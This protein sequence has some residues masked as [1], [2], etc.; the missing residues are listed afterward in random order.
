MKE[1]IL[2]NLE[3]SFTFFTI[4]SLYQDFFASFN[5]Y[6]TNSYV[7]FHNR[8]INSLGHFPCQQGKQ[9]KVL[10]KNNYFAVILLHL[11]IHQ[12]LLIFLSQ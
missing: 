9:D 10:R 5:I 1:N 11:F 7:L 4:F 6:L 8:R 12:L 2:N 3:F